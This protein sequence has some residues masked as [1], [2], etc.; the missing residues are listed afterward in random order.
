MHK[1]THFLL[2][3]LAGLA[4]ASLTIVL[5]IFIWNWLNALPLVPRAPSASPSADVAE[6]ANRV[7]YLE[8]E[9]KFQLKV[10]EWKQDQKLLV[11]GGTAFL[12]SFV[13][14]F[15]GL[16]PYN[17]LDK[18]IKEKVHATLEKELYQL[19]P[20]NLRIWVISRDEMRE[21]TDP[22]TK[23]RYKVNVETEMEKVTKRLNLSGLLN[24]RVWDDLDKKSR[25]GVTIVPVFNGDME[26]DFVKFL[27]DNKEALQAERAAFVLYTL[28]YYVTPAT[29][30][31]YANLATANMPAT[32]A[33]MVLTV[34][35]GLKNVKPQTEKEGA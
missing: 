16:K 31:K 19:D 21:M 24:V 2:G 4:I 5:V 17:D 27:D 6:L 30:E 15:I 29:L 26:K 28:S 3:V 25:R 10:I 7:Q 8:D 20:T 22:K 9:Q 18:V 35:R 34:G 33:S 23:E 13:A 32:A 12:I 1:T 11:L 14:A